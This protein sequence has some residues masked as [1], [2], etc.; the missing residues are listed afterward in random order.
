MS[1]PRNV[2]LAIIALFPPAVIQAGER[3]AASFGEIHERIAG[4]V[5]L[6]FIQKFADAG[7]TVSRH[8]NVVRKAQAGDIGPVRNLIR[9]LETGADSGL[10]L[11]QPAIQHLLALFFAVLVS[12]VDVSRLTETNRG[13]ANRVTVGNGPQP[14]K[15]AN[16]C[17]SSNAQ[18]GAFSDAASG[19]VNRP[20][21]GCTSA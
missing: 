10:K 5:K 17:D 21:R 1:S 13:D 12:H 11:Q 14:F 20:V 19:H 15:A 3:D 9:V 18:G 4:L 7:T 2:P 6:A 16:Q 8:A